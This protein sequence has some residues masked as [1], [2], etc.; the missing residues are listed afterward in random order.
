MSRLFI[1]KFLSHST[2]KF[3]WGTL[4]CIKKFRV[5]KK[6]MHQRG[7]GYHVAPSKTFCHTVPKNFVGEHFAVSEN[8]VYRKILCIRRGYHYT[9]LKNFCLTVPIKF[10]EEPFCVSKEFWYRNVSSK[11][12]GKLQGFV[13]KIF[14]SQDR[15]NFAREPFCFRKFLEGK[16]FY[17]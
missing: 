4:R 5:S 2:E 10:V 3:R 15:K 8:F 12:G 17:G 1:Q 16:I 7:G 9:P 14:I 11:G 6:F 13:K